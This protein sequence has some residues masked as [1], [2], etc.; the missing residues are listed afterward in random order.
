MSALCRSR[1]ELS[2]AYF[3]ANF[4]FDTAENE[5][6]KVCRIPPRPSPARTV[7][8][9]GRSGPHFCFLKNLSEVRKLTTFYL[10]KNDHRWVTFIPLKTITLASAPPPGAQA[11]GDLDAHPLVHLA[12][13]RSELVDDLDGSDANSKIQPGSD[14]KNRNNK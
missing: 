2:N 4:G 3:L 9:G 1:R 11:G 6:C 10:T 13:L 5:P 12:D 7:V 8:L 14:Y